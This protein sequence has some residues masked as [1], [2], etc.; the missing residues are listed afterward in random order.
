MSL[1]QRLPAFGSRLLRGLAAAEAQG[2]AVAPRAASL[3]C[4]RALSRL[5]ALRP[6]AA[7]AAS[8][9]ALPQGHR[10]ALLS[11][12]TLRQFAAAAAA[13]PPHQELGMPSLSPTMNQG[14]ILVWKKKEGDSVQPGDILC[15]VETDKVGGSDTRRLFRA[16]LFVQGTL[17]YFP[18]CTNCCQQW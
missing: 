13:L 9:S 1:R 3:Q 15:D 7:G 17:P 8:A 14:S 16:W 10:S 4:S 11:L 18:G 2:A 6:A 12:H 5:A